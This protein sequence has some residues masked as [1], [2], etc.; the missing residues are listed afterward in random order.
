[1]G[2]KMVSKLGHFIF[3]AINKNTLMSNRLFVLFA[4]LLFV[5]NSAKTQNYHKVLE[6][7]PQWEAGSELKALRSASASVFG[8]EFLVVQFNEIPTKSEVVEMDHQGI[9][10]LE[11]VTD[12]CYL[13]ACNK[14]YSTDLFVRNNVQ[15]VWNIQ[16][17]WK[18]EHDLQH[19]YLDSW[20]KDKNNSF[21]TIRYPGN[22]TYAQFE[23][24]C[25]TEDIQI[26]SSNKGI[27]N[28]AEV[29][30]KKGDEL[31]LL[32]LPFL[33]SIEPLGPPAKPEDKTG[34]SLHKVNKLTAGLRNYSGEGIAALVRDDGEVFKHIDFKGRMIQNFVGESRG[35]HGDG[36][37]GILGGAGNLDPI[38]TGMAFGADIHILDY[39]RNFLDRTMDLH[40]TQDVLV[41][42]SSYSDGCNVGYN[43]RTRTV[44]QQLFTNR[45][46]MH[47][48]SAGNDGMSDCEFGAGPGWGNIT[49]GNKIG[50]N[51]IAVANLN[52][53]G[54]LES[55]SSRG[56]IEDGRIKPDIAANG[57]GHVSTDEAH[58]YMVFGGTSAA[59]PVVAGIMT[60][61]HQAYEIIY[62]ER[63]QADVLKAILLNTAT[64]SGNPGPDYSFGWGIVNAHRAALALEEQ[65]FE[66]RTIE[67]GEMISIPFEIPA[68]TKEI[69]IMTYWHDVDGEQNPSQHLINNVDTY[70]SDGTN[71]YYPWV[72]DP[73]PDPNILALPATTGVDNTNNMEQIFISN[74]EEGTYNL[75]INGTEIPSS[76]IELVVT[77][78][79]RND[80][81]EITYPIGGEN[82]VPSTDEVIHWDAAGNEGEFTIELLDND[83]NVLKSETANGQRRLRIMRVD[84]EFSEFTRVRITRGASSDISDE[85][86]LIAPKPGNLQIIREEEEIALQFDSVEQAVSYNIYL[87]G[88]K[89]MEYHSTIDTTYFILPDAEGFL[90]NWI[91]VSANFENGVEGERARAI[92]TQPAP[93]AAVENDKNDRPCVDQPVTF[94]TPKDS[95]T[96]YE[97]EFGNNSSPSEAFTNG[98]HTVIYDK[99]G[100]KIG[101]LR[102][103]NDA[104]S[105]NTIFQI[106]VQ[107]N[108]TGDQI[109][110]QDFGNGELAFDSN[111]ELVDSFVWDFGDGSISNESNPTHIYEQDGQFNVTMKAFGECGIIELEQTVDVFLSTN[112]DDL[113]LSQLV[114]RPNPNRGAFV[115]D[116]PQV[117]QDVL[118]LELRSATGALVE[119][120]EI[121]SSR[122][123]NPVYFNGLNS[124]IYILTLE[125]GN[126]LVSKRIFVEE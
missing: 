45:S 80:E 12:N 122:F 52:Y 2:L 71:E 96:V 20:S 72:L 29:G 81:I 79:I 43:N 78:E 117:N 93:V 104:G 76:E 46:L 22:L 105:D 17:E 69:K 4:F 35:S 119:K 115:V 55:S 59:A 66:R 57:F 84:E 36:V 13:V 75:V 121:Q 114:I 68:G 62:G 107:P 42:N 63:A 21:F 118:R 124:G 51:T 18:T 32:S 126:D 39:S 103:V 44:D 102:A 25:N 47:V 53:V 61:L 15:R 10:I 41:T 56:P 91:S 58:D 86:F 11:Y 65:R 82:F 38:N 26:I 101:F 64:D 112:V 109:F 60:M 27:N 70:L 88:D 116:L 77:W 30:V 31:R 16:N 83:G 7:A 14:D 3:V 48:F 1:M 33:L 34:R 85:P 19:Q 49:G 108:P 113:L 90:F 5:I 125:V 50:K 120:R 37:A 123:A 95:L 99:K 8:K 23:N 67:N 98:P 89:Y 40:F 9:A 24:L 92:T 73:S 54:L 111:A 74:P 110:I 100:S 28:F 97:W 106:S 87:L 94:F 6:T